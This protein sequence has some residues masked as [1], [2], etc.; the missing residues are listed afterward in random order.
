MREEENKRSSQSSS[1]KRFFQ[2]RWVYPAIYIASAALILTAVLWYQTS[3]SATDTDKYDYKSTDI[4]GKKNETPAIEVSKAF[5]NFKMPMTN[6]AEAVVKMKFYDFNGK[7]EDQEAALVFYNNMYQ[8]NTGIDVTTKDGESFD[9][10]ASLSGTVTRVEEDAVLGNV[11]EIEHAEG[12]VTQ[13]QSVKEIKIKVG[14]EVKQGQALAKAGQSLFNEKAGTHV[15]FEIRKDGVAVNPADYFNKSLSTLQEET[16]SE[17]KTNDSMETP[18]LKDEEKRMEDP[19]S[20]ELKEENHEDPASK[21]DE[22][23]TSTENVNS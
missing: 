19:S 14:D 18:S 22:S 17:D 7:A 23:S 2:K 15:H 13:Y 6:G 11:I 9:V 21:E 8:P 5:E 3:D 4:A 10:V 16:L 12:I 1:I 20:E